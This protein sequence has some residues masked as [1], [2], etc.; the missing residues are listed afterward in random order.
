MAGYKTG[1]DISVGGVMDTPTAQSLKA[2]GVPRDLIIKVGQ[3]DHPDFAKWAAF[4]ARKYGEELYGDVLNEYAH[5]YGLKV[6][7][8]FV[9]T[10]AE[11]AA[12]K[13]QRRADADAEATLRRTAANLRYKAEQRAKRG[14]KGKGRK[15]KPVEINRREPGRIFIKQ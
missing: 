8:I 4:V 11:R 15:S 12:R 1:N 5:L 2:A 9:G 3:G 6:P 7:D 10:R 14:N 13:A